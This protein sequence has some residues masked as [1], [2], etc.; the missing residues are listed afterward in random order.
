[1]SGGTRAGLATFGLVVL[2]F[3]LGLGADHIWLAHRM[4]KRLPEQ[5]HEES[6]HALMLSLQL[7]DLQRE[8]VEGIFARRHATVQQQLAVIHP[9]LRATMDSARQEIE[10]LLNPHQLALFQD[11]TQSAPARVVP[12]TNSGISH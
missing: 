1:M 3:A 5:T 6:Y 9:I 11:W 7:T 2:G 4:H 12:V 10:A 8:A